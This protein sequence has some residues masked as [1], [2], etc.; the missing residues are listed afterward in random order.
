MPAGAHWSLREPAETSDTQRKLQGTR[1]ID[2]WI[3]GAQSYNKAEQR[4]RFAYHVVMILKASDFSA[5]VQALL[6]GAN[7]ELRDQIPILMLRDKN[8]EQVAPL[9]LGAARAFA[10][11][12]NPTNS[13]GAAIPNV[14]RITTMPRQC[15]GQPAMSAA[16]AP[17]ERHLRVFDQQFSFPTFVFGDGHLLVTDLFGGHG[18]GSRERTS[19]FDRPP[20]G[21][22]SELLLLG[23][24]AGVLCCWVGL[25]GYANTSHVERQSNHIFLP[26]L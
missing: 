9:V 16:Q 3:E 4:L 11:G 24:K 17:V 13:C 14:A 22:T 7:P 20:P 19:L 10:A 21:P 18:R 8:L 26:L 1:A 5:V 23:I 25:R 2:R 6:M 15:L 12:P